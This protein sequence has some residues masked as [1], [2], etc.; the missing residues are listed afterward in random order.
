[1]NAREQ[2][3]ANLQ[4]LMDD[5]PTVNSTPALERATHARGLKVGK[6]TIDRVLKCETPVNLDYVEVF[7]LVFEVPLWA[8]LK[9]QGSEREVIA[10]N[11]QEH[12]L[13]EAFRDIPPDEQA[14]LLAKTE[15]RAEHY[16]NQL[17][18]L[19]QARGLPIRPRKP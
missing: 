5:H 12:T 4:A 13:V 17:D 1:M 2:L 3:A 6:S 11:A 9:P 15:M 7:A 19:L 18:K 16:R 8:L 10:L 14:D